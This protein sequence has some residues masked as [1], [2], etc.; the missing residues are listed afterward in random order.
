MR[1]NLLRVL[2]VVAVGL[3]V[4]GA[5][6]F[7]VLAAGVF[8]TFQDVVKTAPSD[9]T[10][11][12]A[13]VPSGTSAE[14]QDRLASAL[15]GAVVGPMFP[16]YFALQLTC[17]IVVT[18]TAGAWRTVDAKGRW[19]FLLAVLAL[20]SVAVGGWISTIVSQLRLARFVCSQRRLHRRPHRGRD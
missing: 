7:N 1:Q 20:L 10:A 2:H 12:V 14:D 5:G 8:P 15:A 4:G 19:R 18:V 6:M 13:I 17:G 11:N 9:R 16:K 3:W